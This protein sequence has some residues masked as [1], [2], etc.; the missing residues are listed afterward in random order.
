MI[1]YKFSPLFENPTP[2]P[3][4]ALAKYMR[5]PGMI[6]FGG[7][8]P[9]P[10]LFDVEGLNEAQA[11][12]YQG[13]RACLAY[14]PTE[15]TPQ[16]KAEVVR[17]MQ[18]R[19]AITQPEKIIVTTGSQQAF[20]L[21]LRVLVAA[22]DRVFVEEPTYSTNI[23]AINNYQ[24]R[25]TSIPVDADGLDVHVL[26]HMLTEARKLGD[27]PKLLYTIP[28]F[29]NP[30]GATLTKDR[31]L[32]LLELAVEYGFVIIEDDPYGDLRFSGE[33]VPSLLALTSQVTAS[34]ACVVHLASLSKIIA[35]GLRVAWAIAP[36][37]I[38]RRCAIAKES[39]DFGSSPWTQN[40]VAEYLASDRLDGHVAT[41]CAA[42]GA[43]CRALASGLRNS[44][45]NAISFH[46][47]SGGMF[48]WARLNGGV[49]ASELLQESI[50]R[51]VIFVPGEGFHAETP[52]PTTLRLSFV[53]PTLENVAE[54][55]SRL[56]QAFQAAEAAQTVRGIRS[57]TQ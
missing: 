52:D 55:A 44:L 25:I 32:R 45:G 11:R 20:D 2:S 4:R 21:V 15:G 50:P 27:L 40:I 16:I 43:K 49:T 23:Q 30:S 47:P 34:D 41:I 13:S 51:H 26:E 18:K 24:A 12:A 14:G 56:G 22:G 29:S 5:E 37:E 46:E 28:T 42:Y 54:G 8:F 7:G 6:S 3:I 19:G 48:I 33:P 9:D 31:R 38:Q 35:P 57:A 10:N 1:D 36:S 39:A 53:Q 17:L